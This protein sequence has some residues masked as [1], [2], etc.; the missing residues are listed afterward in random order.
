MIK[1]IL[2]VILVGYLYYRALTDEDI[3]GYIKP[4]TIIT[5]KI[6]VLYLLAFTI[7]YYY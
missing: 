5:I 7:L 1:E 3:E 4:L 2:F 6:A